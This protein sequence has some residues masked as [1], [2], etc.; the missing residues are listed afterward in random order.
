MSQ[1]ASNLVVGKKLP[2]CEGG[3]GEE[4]NGGGGGG[5]RI[6]KEVSNWHSAS[7]KERSFLSTHS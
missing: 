4:R 1:D 5:S 6:G 3:E 7:E 2:P